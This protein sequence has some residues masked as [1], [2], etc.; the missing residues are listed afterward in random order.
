MIIYLISLTVALLVEEVT[1]I[2]VAV[3]TIT[4]KVVI[5]RVTIGPVIVVVK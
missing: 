4:F 5:R 3:K 1:K 2:E